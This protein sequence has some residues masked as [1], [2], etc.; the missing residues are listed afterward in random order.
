MFNKKTKTKKT[1]RQKIAAEL[2]AAFGFALG[3]GLFWLLTGVSP[4]ENLLQFLGV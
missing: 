3:L 2:K 1:L 4:S